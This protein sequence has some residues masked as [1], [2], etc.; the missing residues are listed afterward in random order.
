MAGGDSKISGRAVELTDPEALAAF[1]DAQKPPPGPF[2]LFVLS[3]E[4]VVHTS[5]GAGGDHLLIETWRPGKPIR[6]VER[7]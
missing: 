5:V 7:R 3:I 4:E 2:H 6:Q 1:A